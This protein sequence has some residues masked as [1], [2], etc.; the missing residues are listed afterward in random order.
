MG[1]CV[2]KKCT[3]DRY[4]N[5]AGRPAKYCNIHKVS[6]MIIIARHYCSQP[7]CI[8][9]AY[10]NIPGKTSQ[11]YCGEHK[12]HGMLHTKVKKCEDDSCIRVAYYNHPGM[13]VRRFCGEH[14]EEG[15][16]NVVKR[17]C[18]FKNCP[19][20]ASYFSKDKKNHFCAEH[21]QSGMI[22]MEHK[23]CKEPGCKLKPSFNFPSQKSAIY[24][25]THKLDGMENV[26]EKKCIFEG[27]CSTIATFGHPHTKTALYC[28]IHCEDGMVDVRSKK[29]AHQGCE[30]T[31]AYNILGNPPIYCTEHKSSEMVRVR[32]KRCEEEGCIIQASFNYPG[33]GCGRFCTEHKKPGMVGIGNRRC[34]SEFCDTCVGKKYDGYC[35]RC[36]IHLYPLDNR[37]VRCAKKSKELKVR[38]WLIEEWGELFIHDTPLWTGNCA[39]PH[40][41][42]IDF[43]CCINK[44]LLA[45]E[46]D[47][48]QHKRIVYQAD[49]ESRY[50]DL[51]MI[52][53]GPMIFI[54]YN[55]DHYKL[56]DGTIR[57]V[58]DPWR[59]KKLVATIKKWIDFA[60]TNPEVD[61]MLH[62]EKLYFDE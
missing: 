28:A 57:K 49:D 23:V 19:K 36:F 47:E 30:E 31:A 21:K 10:F 8:K 26:A 52:H 43:R 20:R 22:D 14:K 50:N 37:S 25:F 29:C 54:R 15:M 51:M 39:C 13:K 56:K 24:C 61:W 32:N 9:P 3:K 35:K 6:D 48:G 41:R 58:K 38:S 55:P 12:K 53:G 16:I 42:R 27:G 62:V 34:R 44:F 40:R 46:V 5:Y 1:K 11:F 45:V 18:Q 4:Y 59:R 33:S 7:G 60:N 2:V 17:L